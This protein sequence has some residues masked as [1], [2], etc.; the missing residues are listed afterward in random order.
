M[1]Y[2]NPRKCIGAVT[3]AEP[4]RM[5]FITEK[6]GQSAIFS[7]DA[8]RKTIL[9]IAAAVVHVA[10]WTWVNLAWSADA[11]DARAA[12]VPTPQA[13]ADSAR[14]L[15]LPGGDPERAERLVLAQAATNRNGF[16]LGNLAIP[17][18][19]IHGGGPP[20]DGIPAIFDP[21]F[22][23]PPAASFLKDSD[24]VIGLTMGATARA[25]P[26][27]ILVWHEIVNDVIDGQPV[28]VTYCPLC[29]TAMVFSRRISSKDHTFGVS[30]LLYNSDVLMY[31]HETESLWSQLKMEAVSGEMMG[32]KL[33]WISSAQ[34]TWGAWRSQHPDTVVLSTD[35]GV[36]RNYTMDPYAGYER[37]DATLFPVPELRS[38]LKRK[39]WVVGVV[40]D[41]VVK[42]YPLASLS[43]FSDNGIVD[44]VG[45]RR[46]RLRRNDDSDFVNVDDASSGKDIPSVR[47][48]WFA[49]QAFYPETLLYDGTTTNR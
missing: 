25:Y 33:E 11:G 36:A 18:D 7:L 47:A 15:G 27:R 49:W 42:A 17:L 16:D 34:M 45:S 24:I 29:G 6:R 41:G 12:D 46:I 10:A 21:K 8:R 26:L 31:D 14:S 9:V 40:V 5:A 13:A 32:Q 2:R 37:K 44:V 48:Y 22:V 3:A 1:T 28:M 35:T 30:G 38:E 43:S 4:Q 19:E 39:E 20:R 23:R